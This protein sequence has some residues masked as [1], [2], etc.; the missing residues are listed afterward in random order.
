MRRILK[1][2]EL[3]RLSFPLDVERIPE[4]LV[5]V[6]SGK[7]IRCTTQEAIQLGQRLKGVVSVGVYVAKRIGGAGYLSLDGSQI[8]GPYLG[9]EV[10]EVSLSE[11]ERWMSGVPLERGVGGG[12]V[13]IVRS[14]WLYLGSG[15][16]SR[17]G[18][19]YPLIPRERQITSRQH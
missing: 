13:V 1:R 9:G 12:G 11:A 10:V 19:I 2:E 4:G 14:G 15:R 6:E 18:K 8:L 17:D 7:R 3:A 5:F 16:A